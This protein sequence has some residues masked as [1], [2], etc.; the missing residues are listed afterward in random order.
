VR[1]HVSAALA[2]GLADKPR[3]DVEKPHVVAGQ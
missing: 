3:L 2:T 1:P